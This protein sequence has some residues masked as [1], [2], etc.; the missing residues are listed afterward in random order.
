M[1]RKFTAMTS[2]REIVEFPQPHPVDGGSEDRA[3]TYQPMSMLP[4]II[5][6]HETDSRHVVPMRWGFPDPKNFQVPQPIHA[7]AE[8]VEATKTFRDAFVSGQR[9]IVVMQTFS[10]SNGPDALKAAPWTIDPGDGVPR[11]LA[12]LWQRFEIA[13]LPAP[14]LAC[15]MV[16]APANRLIRGM[17]KEGVRDPR[18]PA[19]LEEADWSTWLD[20]S[21]VPADQVKA[22]L[23]TMDGANWRISPEPVSMREKP[24]RAA[25]ARAEQ[26]LL[27]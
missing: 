27:S 17:I 13:G 3:V 22:T 5:F 12:V 4:V 24:G 19:I 23:R 7:R 25:G 26:M 8:F 21:D 11:G 14:M 2:W 9:G 16:T 6:D 20:E 10:E 1:C 15:A 18:M